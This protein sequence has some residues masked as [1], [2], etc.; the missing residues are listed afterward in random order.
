MR[1]PLTVAALATLLL[2]TGACDRPASDAPAASAPAENAATPRVRVASVRVR[3]DNGRP[4]FGGS[5]PSEDRLRAVAVFADADPRDRPVIEALVGQA[6]AGAPLLAIDTCV[7]QGS[8]GMPMAELPALKPASWIQ[9]LDV[10]NL[11]L[12]AGG[13]SLPLQIRL[14]PAVIE[15]TRGVRYDAAVERG[16]TFLAS[17]PLAVSGTGGDGVA[18]FSA[19]VAVPRPVRITLVGETPPEGGLVRGLRAGELHVRWGSADASADLELLAGSETSQEPVWL[20]CRP[21]DDGAFT[22][23][24]DL[25]AHLPAR[26]PQRP[27]TV[28]VVR[29]SRA[30]VPGFAGQALVL[31]L[32]DAVHV[33]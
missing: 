33:E 26:S 25:V 11:E 21:K 7:R 22:L 15:A 31:E 16:R 27:W 20:R 29:R 6:A 13:L 1:R 4:E 17:G 3:F 12:R 28:M 9:L 2:G 23:P 18:A 32:A 30:A 14:L 24:V 10:G 19:Q 5:A 8:A